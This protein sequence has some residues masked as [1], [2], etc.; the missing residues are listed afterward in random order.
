MEAGLMEF[1][2]EVESWEE[3]TGVAVGVELVVEAEG[4]GEGIGMDVGLVEFGVRVEKSL[5]QGM[6]T[7]VGMVGV[8]ARVGSWGW[9]SVLVAGK[10]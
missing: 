4:L 3:K 6:G 8:E 9:V 1:G 2:A 7:D 10:W 5:D